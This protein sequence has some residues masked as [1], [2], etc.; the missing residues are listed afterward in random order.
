VVSVSHH[1]SVE[2]HHQRELALLGEGD[3]RLR[4]VGLTQ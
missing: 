1:A 4:R 2:R 3:W